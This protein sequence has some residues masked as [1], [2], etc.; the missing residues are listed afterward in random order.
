MD[1]QRHTARHK[2]ANN[3]FSQFG[4]TPKNYVNEIIHVAVTEQSYYLHINPLMPN[5]F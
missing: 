4:N 1:R 3:H 2:E 5:D